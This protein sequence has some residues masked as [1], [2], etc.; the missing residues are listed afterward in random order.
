MLILSTI[1][2]LYNVF[3]DATSKVPSELFFGRALFHPLIHTWGFHEFCWDAVNRKELEK[4]WEEATQNLHIDLSKLASMNAYAS[5]SVSINV[6]DKSHYSNYKAINFSAKLVPKYHGP[7]HVKRFLT[8]VTVLLED[9]LSWTTDSY[10]LTAAL[11]VEWIAIAVLIASLILVL[12][13][14]TYCDCVPGSQNASSLVHVQL[15]ICTE[16]CDTTASN[17]VPN[18]SL[19]EKDCSYRPPSHADEHFDHRSILDRRIDT[20][21]NQTCTELRTSPTCGASDSGKRESDKGDTNTRAYCPITPTRKALNCHTVLRLLWHFKRP[22]RAASGAAGVTRSPRGRDRRPLKCRQAA[23]SD[24]LS[25]GGWLIERREGRRGG[26]VRTH[27]PPPASFLT[28][29]LPASPQSP[30]GESLNTSVTLPRSHASLQLPQKFPRIY[31]L[32][33]KHFA[34]KGLDEG[35]GGEIGGGGGGGSAAWGKRTTFPLPFTSLIDPV[36]GWRER[37]RNSYYAP[38]RPAVAALAEEERGVGRGGMLATQDVGVNGLKRGVERGRLSPGTTCFIT[39]SGGEGVGPLAG[40][41]GQISKAVVPTGHSRPKNESHLEM[42]LL[43][44]SKLHPARKPF[45]AYKEN[46][47]NGLR[48]SQILFTARSRKPEVARLWSTYGKRLLSRTSADNSS[49]SGPLV[50]DLWAT[51]G[52]PDISR[53][54]IQKWPACVVVKWQIRDRWLLAVDPVDSYRHIGFAFLPL[55]SSLFSPR[56]SAFAQCGGQFAQ[57]G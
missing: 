5:G 34:R 23:V 6:E 35:G 22:S 47:A 52:L 11:I 31:N 9:E 10:R 25:R 36:S 32:H 44:I 14:D 37:G 18:W 57:C 8:P 20:S 30:S 16:Q 21:D 28:A 1:P 46:S 39:R 7:F 53:Q 2:R 49:R 19:S 48:A 33:V 42:N 27:K 17:H 15:G 50:V 12:V 29:H 54:Y 43:F 13:A 38:E 4:V 56:E 55:E 3:S 51:L 26:T 24:R 41:R 45:C 40:G